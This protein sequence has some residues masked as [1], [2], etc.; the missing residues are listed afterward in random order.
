[1]R[2]PVK[3]LLVLVLLSLMCASCATSGRP[4]SK[5]TA[6]KL[7]DIPPDIR[8]CLKREV[9]APLPGEMS[10]EQAA[11]LMAAFRKSDY[12]KSQCGKRLMGWYDAQARAFRR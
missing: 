5:G 10:R 11:Q 9:P 8:A 4:P 6:I 2:S 1:M 7:A 3:S 12:S